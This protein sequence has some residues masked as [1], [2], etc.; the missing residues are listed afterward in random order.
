MLEAIMLI[1]A[2]NKPCDLEHIDNAR[3]VAV[4][5]EHALPI[6]CLMQGQQT[7]ARSRLEMNGDERMVIVCQRKRLSL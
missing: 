1:C 4:V 7:A 6:T 3:V 2:I 5:G